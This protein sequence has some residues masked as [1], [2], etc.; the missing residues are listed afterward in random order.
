MSSE[1]IDYPNGWTLRIQ[2]HKGGH[3]E[4][5]LI[6][7]AEPEHVGCLSSAATDVDVET[8]KREVAE[9]PAVPPKRRPK[10]DTP[11]RLRTRAAS[12]REARRA[13][14]GLPPPRKGR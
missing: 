12:R 14:L 8:F 4:C 6:I 11:S 3:S 7:T 13:A 5:L 2:Q 1:R 9:L 10:R